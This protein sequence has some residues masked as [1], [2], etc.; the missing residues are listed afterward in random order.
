MAAPGQNLDDLRVTDDEIVWRLIDPKYY[1]E[2]PTNPGKR[3]IAVGTFSHTSKGVSLLRESVLKG[4]E[5]DPVGFIQRRFPKFGIAALKAADVRK[6]GCLFAIE[7]DPLYNWPRDCHV[8]IYK[9]PNKGRMK[10]RHWNQLRD[11]AEQNLILEP[12]M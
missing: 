5:K 3:I 8:G 1:V 10:P 2:D 4:Q 12:T 7:T 6:A 11:L 9:A